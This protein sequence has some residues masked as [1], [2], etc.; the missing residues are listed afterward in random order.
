MW[1]RAANLYGVSCVRVWL[2]IFVLALHTLQCA[3]VRSVRFTTSTV[4]TIRPC[5]WNAL[6]FVSLLKTRVLKYFLNTSFCLMNSCIDLFR[7]SWR[8]WFQCGNLSWT[9]FVLNRLY[10]NHRNCE[11]LT[12]YIYFLIVWLS[13]KTAEISRVRLLRIIAP[14]FFL[15]I[16]TVFFL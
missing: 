6:Q 5:V 16:A 8:T 4:R 1:R 3:A 2:F 9:V 13:V 7:K 10:C 12:K 11:Y 15:T 14:P